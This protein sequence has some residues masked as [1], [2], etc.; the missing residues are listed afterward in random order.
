MTA[1]EVVT[2]AGIIGALAAQLVRT[3]AAEADRVRVTASQ[4]AVLEAYRNARAAAVALG[5][6]AEVAVAADSI[7]VRSVGLTDTIVISRR[8][9]PAAAGVTIAP[10]AHLT[11]FG[12]DGLGVG[13]GN[14]TIRLGRGLV[15][16]QLIVSR[17]GRIRVS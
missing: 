3:V 15:V 11:R 1:A 5:R 16:R 10:A 12:S 6:P 7:V 14:A 2:V 13:V 4:G 17:L 8:P 9:G